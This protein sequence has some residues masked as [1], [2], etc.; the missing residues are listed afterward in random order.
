MKI[1]REK[2]ES[3]RNIIIP[4]LVILVIVFIIVV[5]LKRKENM[6]TWL[7]FILVLITGYY[8]YLTNKLVNE[9]RAKRIADFWEKRI[10]DFYKPFIDRL[11]DIKIE[12]KKKGGNGES[13]INKLDD[14]YNFFQ[15]KKYMIPKKTAR[16]IE[17]LHESLWTA[18]LG[19]DYIYIL[20]FQAAE[21]EVRKIIEEEK[22]R[23]EEKIRK[24]YQY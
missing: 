24:I 21:E 4:L 10:L 11:E 15:K 19:D 12:L 17:S 18:L 13:I 5:L 7:V 3:K 9:E 2:I 22:L 6:E 14:L 1:L 23:L 16:E 20:N 8:A